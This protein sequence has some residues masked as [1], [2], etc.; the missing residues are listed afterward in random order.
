M[1]IDFSNINLPVIKVIN[2][3]FLRLKRNFSVLDSPKKLTSAKTSPIIHSS[4]LKRPKLA[5][6]FLTSALNHALEKINSSENGQQS[7]PKGADSPINTNALTKDPEK[8]AEISR[9]S[10]DPDPVV[11]ETP[12]SS[13]PLD[14]MAPK[15]R[16]VVL[17]E[18]KES[19]VRENQDADEKIVEKFNKLKDVRAKILEFTKERVYLEDKIA[20]VN[21]AQHAVRNLLNS[22]YNPGR[23]LA[24]STQALLEDCRRNHTKKLDKLQFEFNDLFETSSEAI[25]EQKAYLR[26][27]IE[28]HER[29]LATIECQKQKSIKEDENPQADVVPGPEITDPSVQGAPVK[30]DSA[31]DQDQSKL[32][33]EDDCVI[34]DR[35]GYSDQS[36][37]ADSSG[38]SGN[39]GE[40][41]SKTTD[42]RDEDA[43]DI[44]EGG[45]DS[46][47]T[48]LQAQRPIQD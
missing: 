17:R 12:P 3:M 16:A 32:D 46:T 47:F 45:E 6:S 28:L 44:D 36:G 30:N 1:N 41:K 37:D 13:P 18:K 20:M 42:S 9:V 34:L 33:A 15:P 48:P 23:E 22:I 11:M 27:E 43:T 25:K 40:S 4:P 5:E 35:S 10:F 2:K 19:L 39:V 24:K 8:S 38:Q 7:N 14:E 29:T 31:V 26:H 21:D